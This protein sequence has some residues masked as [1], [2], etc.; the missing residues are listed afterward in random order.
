MTFDCFCSGSSSVIGLFF[1]F[2]NTT[3][4]TF[5]WLV[6]KENIIFWGK[7]AVLCVVFVI[8]E[9]GW[10]LPCRWHIS[11]GVCARER[12]GKGE[13]KK[14]KW[15]KPGRKEERHPPPSRIIYRKRKMWNSSRVFL[16]SVCTHWRIFW[17]LRVLPHSYSIFNTSLNIFLKNGPFSLHTHTHKVMFWFLPMK[18]FGRSC[19]CLF[20]DPFS[21]CHQRICGHVSQRF[22]SAPPT[23]RVWPFFPIQIG[24]GVATNFCNLS[25][26]RFFFV[27]DVVVGHSTF[28]LFRRMIPLFFSSVPTCNEKNMVLYICLFLRLLF[29]RLCPFLELRDPS[30]CSK[31]IRNRHWPIF[32]VWVFKV[33]KQN[34][35]LGKWRHLWTFTIITTRVYSLFLLCCKCRDDSFQFVKRGENGHGTHEN[36]SAWC[37]VPLLMK[38]YCS[39]I[40]FYL[41]VN[42]KHW[43]SANSWISNL[44]FLKFGGR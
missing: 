26:S 12:E 42:K 15:W 18:T 13:R 36:K 5:R 1:F 43:H 38:R 25:R 7:G 6:I 40:F 16:F 21:A 20:H 35:N 33:I 11:P 8:S 39:A 3:E 19:K 34:K 23:A 10:P 37:R 30:I 28:F 9:G 31:R 29:E 32:C 27:C 4:D 14:W 41:L 17:K 24:G 2:W 44:P 22:F